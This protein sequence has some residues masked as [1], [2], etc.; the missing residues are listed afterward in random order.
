MS[1][2]PTDTLGSPQSGTMSSG[3]IV[4]I[5]LRRSTLLYERLGN[6]K[7]STL[8]TGCIQRMADIA[9]A[10]QGR[11]I[12]SLGDGLMLVY[13]SAYEALWAAD[14]MAD[15]MDRWPSSDFP[16]GLPPLR[17]QSGI[18]QGEINCI[19]DDVFGDAVNVAA[20]LVAMASDGEVLCTESIWSLVDEIHR[21]RLIPI[22]TLSIRGRTQPVPVFRWQS[23]QLRH[24]STLTTAYREIQV[25]AHDAMHLEFGTRHLTLWPDML[26]V[27]MGRGEDCQVQLQDGRVSRIHARVDF[28]SGQFQ[29]TDL[30]YNG[31]FVLLEN[32]EETVALRRGTMTL[33]GSG[34]IGLGCPPG[35]PNTVT[36]AFEILKIHDPFASPGQPLA[37]PEPAV[38]GK[39][40]TDD[41]D[42]PE[43]TAS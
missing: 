5:D 27:T 30:S 7:A 38:S 11:V 25:G 14:E 6:V 43:A 32:H 12:K 33:H 39:T 9:G 3:V 35:T 15:V 31:T 17:L 26:P 10:H 37:M 19:D 13:P 24:D 41:K 23:Q 28:L 29:L 34:A 36:L 42:S 18:A 20:R 1:D 16:A 8:V 22:H 4:F 21:A 40:L 2:L